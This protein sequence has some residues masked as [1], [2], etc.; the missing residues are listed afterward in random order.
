MN[1]KRISNRIFEAQN[2]DD[3]SDILSGLEDEHGDELDWRAIGKTNNYGV[4]K[5]QSPDP[6]ASLTELI[7]NSNDAILHR[8]YREKFGTDE[9]DPDTGIQTYEDAERIL[10]DEEDEQIE[11]I[12]DGEKGE[13]PNIIVQDQGIGQPPELFE[14]SFFDLLIAGA[15]K[16]EWPFQQGQFGMGGSAVMPH[17]GNQGYKL[18][19]SASHRNPETWCWSI[20][21]KNKR[22]HQYEYLTFGGDVFQFE[23]E[24]NGVDHGTFIKIFNY[25]YGSV[26]HSP[27]YLRRRLTKS[28]WY[29]PLPVR[30]VEGREEVVKSYSKESTTKGG[31][32]YFE[33]YQHLIERDYWINE[34]DFGGD[35]GKRDIRVVVAKSNPDLSE[36]EERQKMRWITGTRKEHREQAVFFTVN[37][38]THG[39]LGETFIRN[40][41]NKQKI[42]RDVMVFM[43][44][45][46]LAAEQSELWEL[47]DLFVPARYRLSDTELADDLIEGLEDALKNDPTLQELERRRRQRVL[48]EQDEERRRD[49]I[50][51][52]LKRNPAI[53]RWLKSGDKAGSPGQVQ[54]AEDFE[55]PFIPTVFNIIQK[56]RRDGPNEIWD[57]E[58]G[59]YLKRE[60]INRNAQLRFELDA[61]NDYFYRDD[62]P[63]DIHFY[64][65]DIIK[66]FN[67]DQGI[68][69]LE[70]R[71]RH[72]AEEGDTIPLTVEIER[73]AQDSLEQSLKIEYVEPADPPEPSDSDSESE[74][75]EENLDLPES[76]WV[77]KDK[78]DDFGFDEHS[79]VEV[80]DDDE[81]LM[82]H[83]NM[84]AA[85]LQNFIVRNSIKDD[86]HG[87]IQDY[88]DI[89]IRLYG[90]GQ[91]I[92]LVDRYKQNGR[93]EEIDPLEIISVTMKGVA[94]TMLDQ[95]VSDDE[96]ETMKA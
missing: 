82:F 64:P 6:V 81:E 46:D 70:I 54:E 96:L 66:R 34:Y 42:G 57:A 84:D 87:L 77:F 76:N 68:L 75:Q 27:T 71:P 7:A 30:M 58:K 88:W 9:Y 5:N 40:R 26:G 19:I 50:Q 63:G 37:G 95:H 47:S 35:L 12:T 29:T 31:F 28:L 32:Q 53:K 33:D 38:Q 43:D 49:L 4:I 2:E 3:V 16:R 79:I 45:S 72:G 17:S 18:V 91:Y 24:F 56:M 36:S 65:N 60:A 85:P 55:P 93:H 73:P 13:P 62:R 74:P 15:R 44:F 25:E 59:R 22:K 10:L 20:A 61:P 1:N 83:I 86:Y 11:I 89:G 94:Q 51:E 8:L 92:E 67:L 39:N 80:W 14:E 48:H 41:C 23:G 69:F 78:W 52:I 90:L 21:K